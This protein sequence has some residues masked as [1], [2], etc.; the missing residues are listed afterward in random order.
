MIQNNSTSNVLWDL[1]TATTSASPIIAPGQT[2]FF[3]V[4]TTVVHLQSATANVPINAAS[5]VVLR[6]WL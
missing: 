1:D 3:D 6:G 5:G 2:I 4:Q